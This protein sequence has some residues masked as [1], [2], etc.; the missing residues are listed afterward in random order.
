MPLQ[1]RIPKRGFAPLSREE[2]QVVNL[3]DLVGVTESELTPEL[4]AEYRIVRSAVAPVKLLSM[5]EAPNGLTITVDAVSRGAREK[6]E[7]AGGSVVL[8][9]GGPSDSESGA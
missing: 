8:R 6:V 5:G 2:Y 9:G 3:R 4:L 7:A 1:R